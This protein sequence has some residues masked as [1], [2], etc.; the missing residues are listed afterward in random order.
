MKFRPGRIWYTSSHD[1]VVLRPEIDI[2][3]CEW[4]VRIYVSA[5]PTVLNNHACAGDLIM[6]RA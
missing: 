3:P 4:E 2:P 6:K 1:Y 5:G